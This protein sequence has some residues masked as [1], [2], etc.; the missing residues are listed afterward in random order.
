MKKAIANTA[1][2]IEHSNRGLFLH[3]STTPSFLSSAHFLVPGKGEGRGCKH[4]QCNNIPSYLSTSATKNKGMIS[5]NRNQNHACDSLTEKVSLTLFLKQMEDFSLVRT[6]HR[7]QLLPRGP[8]LSSM[9]VRVSQRQT[10]TQPTW[11]YHW[12]YFNVKS[13]LEWITNAFCPLY[14]VIVHSTDRPRSEIHLPNTH[15]LDVCS[16][17]HPRTVRSP[18]ISQLLLSTEYL[19]HV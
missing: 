8:H 4:N 2:E 3:P 11:I 15:D 7:G 13:L 19:T 14:P 10:F 9:P 5:R 1:N 18:P 6:L 17:T 16:H 12:Q